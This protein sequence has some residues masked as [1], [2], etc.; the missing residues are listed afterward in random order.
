MS[1]SRQRRG[2]IA[3]VIL[4][5]AVLC[6]AGA[7]SPAAGQGEP[8]IIPELQQIAE[9]A[10]S[11]HE[12]AAVVVVEVE[13][14]RI[15]ARVSHPTSSPLDRTLG[16]AY[17]PA[18]TFKL[19]TAVAGLESGM[20]RREER[21][22][23]TGERVVGTRVLKDM[24][25]HGTL[26]FLGAIQHSCN[27]Y[28]WAVGDRVG[29]DRLATVARDFGFGEPTGLGIHG[30]L[31]GTIPDGSRYGNSE[32]DQ[33]QRINAAIGSGDVKV[34]A[35]QLAM[36]YAA[37]A[38]G[39]RL[40]APQ[41]VRGPPVLRRRV[42]ASAETLALIRKGMYRAVNARGGTATAAKRGAVKVVGKTGTSKS[43]DPGVDEPHAWFAG[44]APADHPTIA[45]VVLVE[46]GGIGGQVAA[47]IARTI[48]DGYFTKVRRR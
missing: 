4:G 16:V 25:V 8:T 2:V 18:S 37:L 47:P 44:F 1:W 9:E 46:H 48:I 41:L 13:T 30:D 12:A 31:P 10:V 26:D 34:T 29:I 36:A 19:V 28:F 23:C 7:L 11:G 43:R 32:R 14:G 45:V 40:Y 33:V 27:I 6:A 5:F 38:N 20:A 15:L 3:L 39:G 17:P 22:T 35:V 42:R 21:M 24:D